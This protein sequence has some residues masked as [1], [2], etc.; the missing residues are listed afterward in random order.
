T[1]NAKNNIDRRGFITSSATALAGLT[2]VPS[3]VVSGLGYVA[4][5]DKLNVAAIGI[6]GKGVQNIPSVAE[7]ENIVALCDIDWSN[8]TARM[9]SRYPK[10]KKHKDFRIMLDNQKDI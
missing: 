5:S 2:I 10:A 7:T 8:Y 1:M 9:F 4:P 3:H 6:G